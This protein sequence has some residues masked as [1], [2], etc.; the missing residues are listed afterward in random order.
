MKFKTESDKFEW[1]I[2]E[3]TEKDYLKK[4]KIQKPNFENPIVSDET[5]FEWYNEVK[6]KRFIK[7][8]KEILNINR[9]LEYSDIIFIY[10]TLSNIMTHL[11]IDLEYYSKDIKNKLEITQYFI[12]FYTNFLNNFNRYLL[13]PNLLN[14]DELKIF[15]K[16]FI[17]D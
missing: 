17:K 4:I 1:E 11:F 12:N 8:I 14:L 13:N 7:S 16:N 6:S 3:L 15:L 10:K 9:E 2:L 5:I